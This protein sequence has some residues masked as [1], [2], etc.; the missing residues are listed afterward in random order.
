MAKKCTP[1]FI[2][3]NGFP[4]IFDTTTLH[5]IGSYYRIRSY[6]KFQRKIP[7][8]WRDIGHV[9]EGAHKACCER[10]KWPNVVFMFSKKTTSRPFAMP[11]LCMWSEHIYHDPTTCKVSA[12][13]LL[14]WSRRAAP[15]AMVMAG[16]RNIQSSPRDS[17]SGFVREM[18]FYNF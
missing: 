12:Q 13:N 2:F 5:V 17:S 10:P 1:L 15:D 7:A 9:S 11:I 18:F 8:G 3:P 6:V 4:L 16:R 14:F